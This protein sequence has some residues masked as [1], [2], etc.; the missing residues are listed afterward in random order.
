MNCVRNCVDGFDL[1]TEI[2]VRVAIF[3]SK[4]P[5]GLCIRKEEDNV[6]RSSL[7]KAQILVCT[8][9]GS[10]DYV[11]TLPH[12]PPQPLQRHWLGLLFLS[13]SDTPDGSDKPNWYLC[14]F[15]RSLGLLCVCVCYISF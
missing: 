14:I 9:H 5:E 13:F 4:F 3:S 6:R 1:I 10:F 15:A 2:L 8:E 7:E 11:D 12:L